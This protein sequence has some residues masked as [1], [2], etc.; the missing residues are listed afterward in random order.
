MSPPV[1]VGPDNAI[2]AWRRAE[3][4]IYPV[5]MS[6]AT[7]YEQYITCVRA[8]VD[9]LDDVRTEDDLV[10]VWH[11]RRD[12]ASEII[13][14]LSP[15]LGP[16][17]DREALRDAAF[18]QRHREITRIHAKE[19]A[20]ARLEQARRDRSEWAVLFEDVTPLGSHRLEMH[21]RSGRG[22]HASSKLVLDG[23]RPEFELEVVQLDRTDGAWLVD[24]PPLAPVQRFDSEAEWRARIEQARA[25]FGRNP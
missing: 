4:R 12:L 23:T 14:R 10:T 3:A 20:R 2:A 7:L 1:L 13:A 8:I 15:S 25:T 24:T 22:L 6:N 21:I 18:C 16:L 11:E 9:E 5:V 17:M 19:I